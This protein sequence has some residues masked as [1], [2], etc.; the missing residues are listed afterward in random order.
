LLTT[1]IRLLNALGAGERIALSKLAVSHLE[2]E[3]RP[4]RIAVDISIWLFQV[5]AGRGGKN[6][7]IRTLFYRLVKLLALPIHP[8]FV[9]D[10]SQK[11]PFKRG[12]ATTSRGHGNAP[13]IQRSKELI[14]RF[15]FPWHVAP[16]EA[17][18]EC[19]RLQQAGV[20]DAVMSDDID[21]LMFGSTFM[22]KNF[23]KES[24]TGTTAATHVTRYSMGNKSDVSNVPFDRPGM[25]LFAMLS[26]GD[27]LPSGV[28]KC[29]SKLAAEIAKAGFGEDLLEILESNPSELNSNLNDWRD[30]LQ[31]ELD[32]NE[33]GY[34]TTKH[35]AVRIP[36]TFPD[37]AILQY[38]AKPIVSAD[39]EMEVLRDHLKEA[40][41]QEIDPMSIRSFAAEHLEW[42][43]R[44]GARK[45]IK[46]LAEPLISYRLRLK[47][48]VS[49]LA[50]GTLAPDCVTPWLQKIRRSRTNFGTD[51]MTEFQIEILPVDVVGI[52][53]LSEQ[54][55]PQLVPEESEPSQNTVEII[56]ED[57]AEPATEAA[58]LQ[59]PS[60]TRVTKRYDP[61]GIEKVWIFETVARI[62][63]PE[64]VKQWDDEL[65]KKAA[66]KAAPKKPASRRTGPKKKGPIDPGMKRG[67]ILKYGTLTKER[68]EFSPPFRTQ[69]LEAVTPKSGGGNDYTSRASTSYPQATD[70]EDHHISPSMYAARETTG[71]FFSFTREVDDLVDTFS[72]LYTTSPTPTSKRRPLTNPPRMRTRASVLG[73]SGVEDMEPAV[74]FTDT[75]IPTP[76]RQRRVDQIGTSTP[77]KRQNKLAKR[78]SLDRHFSYEE[79]HT[80]R[81]DASDI[82][83]LEK[84]VG[85]LSLDVPTGCHSPDQAVPRPSRNS[86]SRKK[87]EIGKGR[88]FS[89]PQ[90]QEP[91][92]ST[93]NKPSLNHHQTRVPSDSVILSELERDAGEDKKK[94]SQSSPK[95]KSD[96]PT[97]KPM[98]TIGHVENVTT[99]NGFWKV[100]TS[101]GSEETSTAIDTLPHDGQKGQSKK[102]RLP[103]VSILDMI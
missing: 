66:S 79:E 41:D 93:K 87:I 86:P 60:K 64:I 3:N 14:S 44:S 103:R 74:A 42:N 55:N 75:D 9:Y 39:H 18:A 90:K 99:S 30:R 102:K 7:E 81:E 85:S 49:G 34:F 94:T 22:V 84:A 1:K 6:P 26:G 40:W 43:Y 52:D 80:R 23:S 61:L 50:H 54:P 89:T 45:I 71:E 73:A 48:P 65:A 96:G 33:S 5:Q 31:F 11:P 62:G 10:G 25:I 29:G 13:I 101:A 78:P 57:D 72:N 38:Y 37:R 98:E 92:E 46:L 35:K 76:P 82:C 12:K 32:E 19:A 56:E 68:S 27:Y 36:D 77:M 70:L 47:R 17:E 63:L 15:R 2:R 83:N 91:V 8:L 97:P 28:P 51:G 67:S 20:V 59:T 4:I 100:D 88:L 58:T 53:L 21:T 16:G 69:L 24:G 95:K